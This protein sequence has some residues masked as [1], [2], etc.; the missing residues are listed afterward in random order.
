MQTETNRSLRKMAREQMF[1]TYTQNPLL[2]YSGFMA[3]PEVFLVNLQASL[4]Y[5]IHG[6]FS[7]SL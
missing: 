3:L 2:S 4:T 7:Q 1:R 5:F 6:N